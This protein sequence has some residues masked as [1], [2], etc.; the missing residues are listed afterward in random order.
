MPAKYQIRLKDTSGQVTDIFDSWLRLTYVKQINKPGYFSLFFKGEDSRYDSFILDAQIEVWRKDDT[1]NLDWYLDFEGL[2]RSTVRQMTSTGIRMFTVYGRGYGDFLNRRYILYNPATD[3]VNKNDVG[4]TVMKEYVNENLGSIATVANGRLIEGAMTGFSV[5]PDSALGT[6]WRGAKVYKNLLGTLQEVAEESGLDFD[7][8]GTGPGTFEFRTHLN[9]L[10]VDRSVNGLV[11]ATGLNG[12]GNAP[13]IFTVNRNNMSIPIF[14]VRRTKEI[15]RLFM[16]GAGR[17]TDRTRVLVTNGDDID[18]PW[19]AIEGTRQS[20][21]LK[22]IAA[23]QDFGAL[24]IQELGQQE[25]FTWDVIQVP[26]T[27]YGRDYFFGDLV[28]GRFD[29]I[30]RSKKI[31]QVEIGVSADSRDFI[32]V[33]M[34]DIAI[35]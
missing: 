32:R 5:A 33:E 24:K 12:A 6:V 21:N 9:Q 14:T 26:S 3:F 16:L 30:E 23:L 22:T 2:A 8:V 34:S 35:T 28:T 27:V 11:A 10:G 25:A 18:S 17:G 31:S 29:D 20:S 4:E 13:V 1:F 19:N 15:N 7:V